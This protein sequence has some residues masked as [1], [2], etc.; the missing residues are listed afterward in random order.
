MGRFPEGY[1]TYQ[2][3]PR[4][5]IR[6]NVVRA[7][8]VAFPELIELMSAVL[9]YDHNSVGCQTRAQVSAR[10]GRSVSS[11][12]ELHPGGVTQDRARL[13]GDS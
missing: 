4:P 8:H 3:A 12:P 10:G 5:N 2:V 9:G 13:L 6:W 7:Q 1:C 11:A